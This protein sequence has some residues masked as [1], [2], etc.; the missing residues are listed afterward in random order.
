MNYLWIVDGGVCRDHIVILD[1]GT[2]P[3]EMFYFFE[4]VVA[5]TRGKA[6]QLCMSEFSKYGD[7]VD[8]RAGKLD[9]IN[10]PV[11]IIRKKDERLSTKIFNIYAEKIDKFF[12]R[13]NRD[14]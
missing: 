2:G 8:L 14:K 12:N 13:K 5:P 1:D 10:Y 9:I 4:L 7:Y 6:K 3:D 11:G